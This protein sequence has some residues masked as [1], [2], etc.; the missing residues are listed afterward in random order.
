M[1]CPPFQC[2]DLAALRAARR[3]FTRQSR[4]VEE[5]NGH[6]A[7]VDEASLLRRHVTKQGCFVNEKTSDHELHQA[8]VDEALPP[9]SEP[10]GDLC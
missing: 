6:Q 5:H 8:L 1:T 3:Q 9:L 4:S 2:A 10:D 7:P